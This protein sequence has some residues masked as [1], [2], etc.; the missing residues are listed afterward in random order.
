[1]ITLA[2]V[3]LVAQTKKQKTFIVK[4]PV[5]FTIL[6]LVHWMFF[7]TDKSIMKRC[8]S[9]AGC[10]GLMPFV[11]VSKFMQKLPSKTSSHFMQRG[12][13]CA[14]YKCS[15]KFGEDRDRCCV[16]HL[17][18]LQRTCCPSVLL[19]LSCGVEFTESTLLARQCWFHI[20]LFFSYFCVLW[21]TP[22][23]L[24]VLSFLLKRCFYELIPVWKFLL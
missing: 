11:L 20:F 22:C 3:L 23:A 2:F 17:C 18:S 6:L 7:Y 21:N 13:V 14:K 24:F 19:D 4:L 16:I 15:Y 8:V 9:R 10:L 1:M 5:F 12:G